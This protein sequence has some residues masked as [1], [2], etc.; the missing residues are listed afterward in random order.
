MAAR[1]QHVTDALRRQVASQVGE[2]IW[3]SPAGDDDQAPLMV[4]RGSLVAGLNPAG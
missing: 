2:L 4:R 1:Y 3:R